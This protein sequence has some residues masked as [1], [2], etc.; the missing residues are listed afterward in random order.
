MSLQYR[1]DQKGGNLDNKNNDFRNLLSL[2]IANRSDYGSH[3][4]LTVKGY[5][6]INSFIFDSNLLESFTKVYSKA[7]HHVN[8]HNPT[9]N[10]KQLKTIVVGVVLVSVRKTTPPHHHTTPG[11]ITIRAVL[12]NVG[13]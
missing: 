8:C 13:S 7:L 2:F 12:G 10:P 3:T 4:V 9:N 1:F 6:K 5:H 11:M